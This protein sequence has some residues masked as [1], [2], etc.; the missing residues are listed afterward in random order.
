[1]TYKYDSRNKTMTTNNT[2]RRT[3]IMNISSFVPIE[4]M[5]TLNH[6]LHFVYNQQ[7][8]FTYTQLVL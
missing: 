4:N 1:M 8:L 6:L 3:Y 2:D 7:Q 5:D